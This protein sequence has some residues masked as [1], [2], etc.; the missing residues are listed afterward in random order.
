MDMQIVIFSAV[1][2][3]TS[4]GM[5]KREVNEGALQADTRC[6]M[7]LN[8]RWF[9]LHTGALFPLIKKHNEFVLR[10]LVSG[11]APSLSQPL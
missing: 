3:L 2:V 9:F 1:N 5:F 10:G 7:K 4:N 11:V 6:L 8:S